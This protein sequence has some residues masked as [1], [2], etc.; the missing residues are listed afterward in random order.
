[1]VYLRTVFALI[2]CKEASLFGVDSC[3]C[4]SAS[5]FDTLLEMERIECPR[6]PKPPPKLA[7][8]SVR[9][10]RISLELGGSK[11]LTHLWPEHDRSSRP[12]DKVDP[13]VHA[14]VCK[15]KP[16]L[17]Q[18]QGNIVEG[19]ATSETEPY[20]YTTWGA[21]GVNR[22]TK[23]SVNTQVRTWRM[24]L[25]M[26]WYNIASSYAVGHSEALTKPRMSQ[27]SGLLGSRPMA[28]IPWVGK[29]I[30]ITN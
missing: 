24:T 11:T 26:S 19:A 28:L 1:M 2:A 3:S 25:W 17:M 9:D 23:N 5:P 8:P 6:Q 30:K 14:Q 10:R 15:G 12:E 13:F 4:P 27:E 7:Q 16:T 22:D 21:G 29:S 20:P 18:A